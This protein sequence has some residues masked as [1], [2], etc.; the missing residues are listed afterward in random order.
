MFGNNEPLTG[1]AAIIAATAG[2][3]VALPWVRH[4]VD[5]ITLAGEVQLF[6]PFTIEAESPEGKP[7]AL[8][9]G[10]AIRLAGSRWATTASTWIS[11]R[12]WGGGIGQVVPDD[13]GD[14]GFQFGTPHVRQGRHLQHVAREGQAEN[15]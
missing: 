5:Q 13:R 11:R 3:V 12:H 15:L 1:R 9:C 10:T 14:P 2:A 8:P 6:W 4:V 7:L